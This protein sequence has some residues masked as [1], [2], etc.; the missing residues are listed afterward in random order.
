MD[1]SWAPMGLQ[2]LYSKGPGELAS[3]N[4]GATLPAGSGD[5][6]PDEPERGV[7]HW[8]SSRLVEA[9]DEGSNVADCACCCGCG[10]GGGGEASFV[11]A[12]GDDEEEHPSCDPRE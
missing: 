10:V 6:F 5:M 7:R 4:R 12:D 9:D 2:T 1:A 3:D 8:S 11:T